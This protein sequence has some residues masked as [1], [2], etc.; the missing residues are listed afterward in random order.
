MC[1]MESAKASQAGVPCAEILTIH[2][3]RAAKAV[4]DMLSLP[5]SE[6]TEIVASNLG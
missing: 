6:V 4:L 1:A 3:V 2:S 5:P